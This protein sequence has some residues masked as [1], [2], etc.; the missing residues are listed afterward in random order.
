MKLLFDHNLS[1]HLVGSLADLF[2]DSEHVFYLG[3]DQALDLEIWTFAGQHG[4]T[5]VTKD[6]DYSDLSVLYGTPPKV[7]WL[8]LGNCTTAQVANLLREHFQGIVVFHEDSEAL[9]LALL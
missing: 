6:A 5:I 3:L 1:P 4:Y 8:R 7:I 9:V 2:P